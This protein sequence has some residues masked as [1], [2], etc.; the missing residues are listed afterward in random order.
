MPIGKA[1]LG[2]PFNAKGEI[3]SPNK[4]LKSSASSEVIAAGYNGEVQFNDQQVVADVPTIDRVVDAEVWCAATER[5]VTEASAMSSR[6]DRYAH[7]SYAMIAMDI[8]LHD[9]AFY[10]AML[11]KKNFGIP[12]NRDVVSLA[13]AFHLKL[14]VA[15]TDSK[16]KANNSKALNR[17]VSSIRQLRALAPRDNAGKINISF[18]SA[19]VTALMKI[20]AD[21]GGIAKLEAEYLKSKKGDTGIDLIPLDMDDLAALRAERLAALIATGSEL[22][23]CLGHRA[24]PDAVSV[25]RE[26]KV[27]TAVRN[28]I[29]EQVSFAN[30]EVAFLK[31]LLDVG[32]C[33]IEQQT[34]ILVNRYDD[35]ND[36]SAPRRLANRHYVFNPAGGITVSPISLAAASVILTVEPNEVDLLGKPV[37]GHVEFRTQQLRSV[38]AN[39][40]DDRVDAF[41]LDVEDTPGLSSGVMRLMLS[42]KAAVKDKDGH[43]KTVNLLV[44]QCYSRRGVLPLVLDG[45]KSKH[46]IK[47][48]SL[49]TQW[50]EAA[51][52]SGDAAKH[53]KAVTISAEDGRII[54]AV[55]KT[56]QTIKHLDAPTGFTLNVRADDFVAVADALPPAD[57]LNTIS[58]GLHPEM[59]VL[60]LE[61]EAAKYSIHIPAR[62]S[63]GSR[64]NRFVTKLQP[65]VWPGLD[66]LAE[67]DADSASE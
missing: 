56:K 2:S 64:S 8:E 11:K 50:K 28:A 16:T 21:N 30:D 61:T 44:Q 25:N 7:K 38:E 31:E 32:R 24:Q 6:S 40:T 10:E 26:L 27:T 66:S 47:D 4:S 43:G 45:F 12:K 23:V 36:R 14:D 41:D 53:G 49:Y 54:F 48:V 39:L 33:V 42:S 34:D 67:D 60:I 57:D 58:L 63:D 37:Q 52:A 59:L 1:S 19:G 55:G 5:S 62:R 35:P 29:A 15:H 20:I 3:M 51:R 18:D 46:S 65:Q 9:A 13:A 17:A 22:I